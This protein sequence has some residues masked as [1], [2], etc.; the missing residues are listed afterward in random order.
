MR[1]QF[2]SWAWAHAASATPRQRLKNAIGAPICEGSHCRTGVRARAPA[3][4]VGR[5]GAVMTPRATAGRRETG[6]RRATW[7]CTCGPRRINCMK[8]GTAVTRIRPSWQVASRTGRESATYRPRWSADAS[9]TRGSPSS[10][11]INTAR[12]IGACRSGTTPDYFERL[13]A[14]AGARGSDARFRVPR[15]PPLRPFSPLVALAGA[16]AVGAAG[17][18]MGGIRGDPR[19]S[20]CEACGRRAVQSGTRC[21]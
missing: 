8:N 10:A 1:A 19:G 6:Q 4:Y 18:V 16:G 17:D 5:P 20:R 13:A 11:G 12:A 21:R 15:L 14:D 2:N 3:G 7:A 9:A